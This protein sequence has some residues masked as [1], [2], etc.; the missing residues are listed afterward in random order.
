[1]NEVRIFRNSQNY[2]AIKS[3]YV[4]LLTFREKNAG[5]QSL[6]RASFRRKKLLPSRRSDR[7]WGLFHQHRQRFLRNL[8]DH[9]E[10]R[11]YK[12]GDFNLHHRS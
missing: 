9:I 2:V 11:V 5:Q 8:C 6:A 1:M 12:F 4:T 3:I 7:G 10:F